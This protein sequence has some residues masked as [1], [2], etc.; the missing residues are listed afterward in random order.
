LGHCHFL[1]SGLDIVQR[2]SLNN[3]SMISFGTVPQCPNM[4]HVPQQPFGP[5]VAVAMA[6]AMA[7]AVQR[8]ACSVQRAAVQRAAAG[9]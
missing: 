8:A 4:Q 3:C 6:M 2:T 5:H 7:M 1:F 9:R